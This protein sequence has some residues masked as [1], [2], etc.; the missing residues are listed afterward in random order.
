MCN[1]K[2]LKT[3]IFSIIMIIIISMMMVS[4]ISQANPNLV[5]YA[6]TDESS[7]YPYEGVESQVRQKLNTI[8]YDYE[9]NNEEKDIIALNSLYLHIINNNEIT[10][11]DAMIAAKDMMDKSKTSQSK[12]MVQSNEY[13]TTDLGQLVNGQLVE[14]Q[15]DEKLFETTN[16]LIKV[17]AYPGDSYT[18]IIS[19]GWEIEPHLVKSTSYCQ[20]YRGWE[21]FDLYR[22]STGSSKLFVED[23]ETWINVGYSGN[24]EKSDAREF[25][26]K[27]TGNNKIEQKVNRGDSLYVKAWTI[28]M[29]R[30]YIYFLE[31]EYEAQYDFY[32]YNKLT[33]TYSHVY[34]D[35]A[36]TNTHWTEKDDRIWI[37]ENN[38]KNPYA[39]SPTPPFN[40]E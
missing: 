22:T 13:I 34:K 35:F 3:R 6:S 16:S 37:R 4:T 18:E 29:L 25:G 14:F 36:A 38:E 15:M 27:V 31:D 2:H 33:N 5:A 40:W 26:L 9:D 1:K 21:G 12:S 19:E 24:L 20:Y 28:E 17:P 10:E 32:T 39:I 8:S 7:F 30:P 11:Q 23:F